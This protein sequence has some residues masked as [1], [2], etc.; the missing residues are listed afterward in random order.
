MQ[1]LYLISYGEIG[2]KGANRPYFERVLRNNIKKVF[3]EIGNVNVKNTHGRFFIETDVPEDKV[4]EQLQRV[5]GIVG[6]SPALKTDLSIEA[7]GNAAV[8]LINEYGDTKGKTF[9]V[10]TRR[11]NK[12]FHFKSPEISAQVGG[13]ILNNFDGL[14]VDVH[15]PEILINVEVREA[16]YVY[17]YRVPGPGGLPIGVS[18]RAMLLLSGGIDSPVAGWMTMKR[19]V[20]IQAVY[21]HSF[22]FTTDRAKQKVIDLC[23]V[24]SMYS[25][26]IKLHVV[27]FTDVLKD[28]NQNSPEDYIT[29]LMRR[30]MVRVAQEIAKKEKCLALIT[31]E[32][33]GQV[34]SQTMESLIATNSVAQIPIF[35][36]LIAMDKNEIIKIA[37]RI[38]SYDISIRPYEDCCTVFVPEH[39]KTRPQLYMVEQAE[40]ALDTTAL[41]QKAL[42]SIDTIVVEPMT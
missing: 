42:S 26:K 31:G 27:H 21:F 30:M 23:K 39:P 25:G 33:I 11:P 38:D 2:L 35:R 6:I 29:L 1:R 12:S 28:L 13:F 24:L 16:G 37:Q 41:T 4:M 20:E 32:S 10:E 8:K 18:G 40:A 15:K 34:A 14:S 22:P 3:E 9:K 7:I 36:P 5:F 19:G 17:C